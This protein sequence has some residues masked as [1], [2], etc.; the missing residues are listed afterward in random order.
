MPRTR[1]TGLFLC[2]GLLFLLG[3]PGTSAQLSAEET[4]GQTLYRFD[5]FPSRPQRAFIE[6]SQSHCGKEISGRPFRAEEV[7]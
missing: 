2:L 5:L 3:S 1:L 6:G 7:A 4:K